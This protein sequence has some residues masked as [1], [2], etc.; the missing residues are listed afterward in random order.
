MKIFVAGS[1]G[2]LARALVDCAGE[3]GFEML[4]LGRP[5]LDLER[6]QGAER[7]E[8]FAP[9]VV[10]NAAAYTAVD[11]AET[12]SARAFAVNRDGAA[13]LAGLATR[14]N[15]PFLHVSTDYVFDGAKDAAYSE[16]D[17]PN[18]QTAYGRTKRAGEEVVLA[19]CPEALIFRTAWVF[20]PY[21]QNF[22]KTMLRLAA[23]RD[24]VRVVNDQTGNPTAAHDIARALLIIAARCAKGGER[25]RGIYHLAA[26]G[27]TTWFG[28]AQAIM[29][30]AAEHGYRAVPV[31]PIG[32]ADYPTAAKRPANSRLDCSRLAHD[33]GLSLPRWQDG[34]A[35]TMQALAA[36]RRGA[37]VRIAP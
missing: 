32:T 21:G 19:T 18:P 1:T 22:V 17:A 15:V 5:Q 23:E 11:A 28:F 3:A 13:W 12:D 24:S 34:L 16:A 10:I 30:L 26:T 9:D 31:M 35:A 14:R 29:R 4:A 36:E 8:D 20:S 7:I 6:R 33:F 37:R 25:P 2:Q 27:E